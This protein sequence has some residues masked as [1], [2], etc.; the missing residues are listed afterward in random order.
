MSLRLH[1]FSPGSPIVTLHPDGRVE[2]DPRS[3]VNDAA[4]QFWEA[5]RAMSPAVCAPTVL[6]EHVLV[7]MFPD[8]TARGEF[9]ALYAKAVRLMR[10]GAQ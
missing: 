7:A 2:I 3:T 8:E 1:S 6:P 5:V 4:R 9:A 10:E